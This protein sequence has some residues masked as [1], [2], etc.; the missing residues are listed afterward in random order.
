MLL[1]MLL[2]LLLLGVFLLLLG[3]TSS[4]LRGT[5]QFVVILALCCPPHTH[6]HAT[7]F[8]RLVVSA[9]MAPFFV[10]LETLFM[11]GY[12]PAWK[13]DVEKVVKERV[14]ELNSQAAKKGV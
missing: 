8:F 7:I 4:G 14:K 9:R 10:L 6:P 3:V 11:M 1:L 12:S 13:D 2:L 5:V